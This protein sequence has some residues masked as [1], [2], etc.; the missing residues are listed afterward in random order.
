[1]AGS[2]HRTGWRIGIIMA[3]VLCLL[4]ASRVRGYVMPA[5]QILGLMAGHFTDFRSVMIEQTVRTGILDGNGPGTVLRERVWIRIPDEYHSETPEAA[6]EEIETLDH[7]Y[8]LLLM[9]A[10]PNRLQGLL[11]NMGININ[12]VAF[13]RFEGTVAYRIGDKNPDRPRIIIEKERFLPVFLAYRGGD[14][15]GEALIKITFRDYRKVEDGW[16]PFEITYSQDPDSQR[17]LTVLQL[18][19]NGPVEKTLSRFPELKGPEQGKRPA[20]RSPKKDEIPEEKERLRKILEAF[21]KKYQ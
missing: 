10:T 20:E 15:N 2:K 12:L 14:R 13:T 6:P 4:P 5:E 17:I 19:V 18:Q 8:R 3:A 9:A 7:R 21:K 16:Y 11:S 1:M